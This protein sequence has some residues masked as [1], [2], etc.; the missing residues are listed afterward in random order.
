MKAQNIYS[1]SHDD[2]YNIFEDSKHRIWIATYGGG[3]NY[4]VE[5]KWR[6]SIH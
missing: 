5:E 2:V 1:L 6:V 4:M 3:L